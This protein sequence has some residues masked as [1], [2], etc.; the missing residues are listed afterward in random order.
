MEIILIGVILLFVMQKQNV[1]QGN[2]FIQD[3]QKYFK[4]LKEE[5]YDFLAKAKYGQDVDIEKLFNMRLRN[6]FLSVI[7]LIFVFLSNLSFINVI[8]SFLAGYFI[9]KS[10]YSK[11]KSNYKKELHNIYLQLPYLLKNLEILAQHYTIPNALAKSA[12]SAPEI[13]KMGLKDLVERINQGDSSIDP[14]MSFAQQYP[15]NDSMR[16]MRLLYR[17]SLGGQSNKHEQLIL[18][19]KS[20]SSLQNKAR[21]TKYKERLNKMENKTM[22]MLAVTG[23]GVM[24]LLLLSLL[25]SMGTSMVG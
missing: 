11:F 24:V 18:F 15:V 14:Y 19:S 12:T 1:I 9:F 5:D 8:L 10:S 21:E 25:Q 13:F 2:K 17:L 6:A 20:V 23:G 22:V 7:A 4:S 3:N 16:M